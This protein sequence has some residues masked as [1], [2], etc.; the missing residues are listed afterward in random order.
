M[1]EQYIVKKRE[2]SA[3]SGKWRPQYH[4]TA[5]VSWMNDPN[6]LIYY[7]GWYH[8]FYQYNPKNCDWA[9]MHWGHAVS[10]DMIRWQDMPIALKPDQ[11][12]DNH[13]EGGCFSGSAVEKDGILYIFYTATAKE[14]GRT[15]Q[16]QCIAWSDDGVHFQKYEGNPVVEKPS[17]EVSDDFRDPKVF[18]HAGKWYMV[19][20][21][22]IG[23]ADSGGDGRVFLY[24]SETIFDWAY[25][26]EILVSGGKLGTMFECPDFFEINGKWVLTCS[27]MN[28]PTLNKALYCVGQMDF[29]TGEYR[30]EKIGTLD[31]GFDYYAPQTFLDKHGNRVMVAWQNGWL[32]MPWCEDWGPTSEENWRGT[33]SIPRVVT[34]NQKDEICLYPV[35]ELETLIRSRESVTDLTVTREKYMIRPETPRSFSLRIR[36]DIRKIKSR[37]LEIGVL[38]KGDHATVISLDL[39]ENILSLDK[40]NGDLYGR[41]RMNRII[42]QEK[43]VMELLILVDCSSVEVYAEHGRYCI[44]SNVYP[45][46][47]QTECWIRTP[48]KDAVIDEVTVYSMDGI[49]DAAPA[50]G[51]AGKEK[52]GFGSRP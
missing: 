40:N 51:C 43:D 52:A 42:R 39:L 41:G 33:F 37:Y 48:Y 47:D 6:G 26:G 50:R 22:S 45:E 14:N 35:K 23:G 7:K 19:V 49:W 32:W 18:E 15:R 5:P 24:E 29:R 13:P 31:A 46:R 30:I 25:K 16:T 4:F 8:L 9:T 2:T 28:H 34:M 3:N 27:P 11:P 38:G 1:I 20:G 10:R 44:T 36:L 21:G 12:Y 17:S